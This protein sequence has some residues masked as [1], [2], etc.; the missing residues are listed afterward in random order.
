MVM[1]SNSDWFRTYKVDATSPEALATHPLNDAYEAADDSQK[2]TVTVADAVGDP[3]QLSLHYWVEA[4]H[5]LNRNGEA[6]PSEYATKIV[7]NESEADLKTFSTNID[8]SRN[9]NMGRVSYYWDG[10]DRAGNPLHHTAIVDDETYS[11]ESGPGFDS[12]DATFRSRKD[13]SAI[14]TGLEWVGHNE[15]LQF[16]LELNKQSH[17]D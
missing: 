6:D 7:V 17:S 5:D 11:W 13:S 4:D 16:S 14:F 3:T 12:D 10:G 9:P 15:V 2:V 1:A 8:H